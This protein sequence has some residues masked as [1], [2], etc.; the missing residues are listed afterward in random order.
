MQ[1]S[2]T[3]RLIIQRKL[4]FDKILPGLEN[5]Q[6]LTDQS[7][8]YCWIC[9]NYIISVFFWTKSLAEK[10]QADFCRQEIEYYMD[11]PAQ[12]IARSIKRQSELNIF[13]PNPKLPLIEGN[14]NHWQPQ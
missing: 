1:G 11:S 14:F 12:K 6:V 2:K 4:G 10:T 9:D 5:W 8:E 3:K 13:N 7:E